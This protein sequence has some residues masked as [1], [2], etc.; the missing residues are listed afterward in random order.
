MEEKNYYKTEDE[1]ILEGDFVTGISMLLS[2][3]ARARKLGEID[4]YSP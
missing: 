1:I 2:M 4:V 3:A